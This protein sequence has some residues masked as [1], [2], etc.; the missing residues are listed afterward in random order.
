VGGYY[1]ES[2]GREMIKASMDKQGQKPLEVTKE[3]CVVLPLLRTDRDTTFYITTPEE[4][5]EVEV[6]GN[7][8]ENG[9]LLD[10]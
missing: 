9:E 3:G 7:I 10:D 1:N 4:E 6:I 5:K 8:H 2:E